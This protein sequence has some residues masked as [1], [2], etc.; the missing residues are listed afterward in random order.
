[1]GSYEK[2]KKKYVSKQKGQDKVN[3][4]AERERKKLQDE[5]TRTAK[6]RLREKAR[7][8]A[9]TKNAKVESIF[10]F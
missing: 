6:K 4:I 1:M 10:T 5:E 2:K 9:L 7:A 8:A 3:K